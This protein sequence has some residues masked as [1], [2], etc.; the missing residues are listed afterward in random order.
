ML[1][2]PCGL[3]WGS[4]RQFSTCPSRPYSYPRPLQVRIGIHTGLVVAGEMGVGDQPEPLAIVGETPNIA[5]RLQEKAEP[6]S[7]V[8]SPT[9]YRLVSGLFECQ[10]LGPQALKGLST[11]SWCTES[12]GRVRRRVAL[13]WRCKRA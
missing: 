3:A 10:E 7:V 8:I 12:C 4:S 5:A 13:R 2:G 1:S 6:N 11:P 9:T